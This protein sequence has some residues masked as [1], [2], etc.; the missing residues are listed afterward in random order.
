MNPASGPGPQPAAAS[1]AELD[2]RRLQSIAE[3]AAG[4]RWQVLLT[5]VIVVAIV[6]EEVPPAAAL[7]WLA[8]AVG[9]REV[10]AR[11]LGRMVSDRATPVATRLRRTVQ[12]NLALG[13]ANGS[14]A[15][16]M[17][18]L[19]VTLD[20][21]LTMI[22]VS[23]GAGAVSTSA[24]LRPAFLAYAS[25]VFLPIAA[26]WMAIGGW[27]G[28]GLATLVLMFFGVQI[29]FARQNLAMF[30]ESFRIRRENVDLAARLAQESAELARA[31]DEAV[32][33]NLAKSHFL[34]AASHDLRQP[35]Q[36][37][38]LNSGELVRLPVGGEAQA[39]AQEVASSIDDLRCML[40]G[41]LDVSQL[42]VGVVAPHPRSF[43]LRRLLEAVTTSFRAA[44]ASRQLTISCDCPASITVHTDPELLR[45]VL[46]NLVDNALKFTHRGGVTVL[47]S[48]GEAGVQVEVRDTG[49]GIEPQDRERIFDDLV[50]LEG[51]GRD[52]VPGHG[53]GLG[54]VRRLAALLDIG[55]DLDSAPGQG[56][57]FRLTLAAGQAEPAGTAPLQALP[58]LDGLRVLVVE[59]DRV[60]REAYLRHL[61][62]LGCRVWAAD[63]LTSALELFEAQPVQLL[64]VD[65]R[66][67]AG[68]DGFEVV[69]RLR[70]RDAALKAV[71][72]SADM[73]ADLVQAAH[74][75]DVRLL[76]KP[77]D[78][79][80]LARAVEAAAKEAW[81]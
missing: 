65:F 63:G 46:A 59:D 48:V 77:V 22:L 15:L 74:D 67:R 35:L 16:F 30:E 21:V 37:L 51:G 2:E 27:L 40:D 13:L 73:H 32:R 20:A 6:W 47:A 1:E 66:L 79:G 81:A 70:A 3:Q 62:R 78:E 36:A 71:M 12:W 11:A 53:L 69:R 31:R 41:L 23:W 75:A 24:T 45:R 17:L 9:I 28:W 76:R 5:A 72:V 68:Q 54:I 25:A 39:I 26:M 56:T 52:N 60:V 4:L 10:R 18:K 34:A 42:D 49:P 64:V 50:R 61:R 55:L 33:A 19:D 8:L 58:E 7:L 80:A 29:R 14:A 57:T 43:P 38:A 44:A